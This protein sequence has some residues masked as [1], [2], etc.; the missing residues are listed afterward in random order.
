[1]AYPVEQ[2]SSTLPAQSESEKADNEK[3]KK[4]LNVKTMM[5]YCTLDRPYY[6]FDHIPMRGF[7][8]TKK[9]ATSIYSKWEVRSGKSKVLKTPTILWYV[10]AWSGGSGS[11]TVTDRRL[12]EAIGVGERLHFCIDARLSNPM[13]IY[14]ELRWYLALNRCTIP[15]KKRRGP[16]SF[17]AKAWQSSE[18]RLSVAAADELRTIITLMYTTKYITVPSFRM[19]SDESGKD[20][21]NPSIDNTIPR[22]WFQAGGPCFKLY[23]ALIKWHKGFGR[24]RSLNPAGCLMYTSSSR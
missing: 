24:A 3:D 21:L 7:R 6:S 20:D 10:V 13:H 12:V 14:V 9:L 17:T 22:H 15:R 2:R 4:R 23:T 16:R 18:I 19:K 1:M 11:P 8:I 5:Y